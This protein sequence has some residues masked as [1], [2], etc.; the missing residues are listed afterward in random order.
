MAGPLFGSSSVQNFAQ[1]FRSSWTPGV[2][3]DRTRDLVPRSSSP[4]VVM[5]FY[6]LGQNLL[7]L[8][9]SSLAHLRIILLCINVV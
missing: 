6:A 3:P 8:S 2:R 9:S 4:A 5:M 7:G 1:V